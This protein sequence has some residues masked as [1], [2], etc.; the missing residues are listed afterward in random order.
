PA[1]PSDG[2]C[3][4]GPR[5]TIPGTGP[6]VP[7]DGPCVPSAGPTV[8]DRGSGVTS[9]G[10]PRSRAVSRFHAEVPHEFVMGRRIQA[11]GGG[12]C[13]AVALCLCECSPDNRPFRGLEFLVIRHNSLSKRLCGR[14]TRLTAM[15][16]PA[17]HLL[18]R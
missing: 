7:C 6:S 13:L 14:A 5:P 12:R 18:F 11:K 3:V 2:R 4:P 9:R 10:P 17:A 15:N 16:G 1:I 8:P